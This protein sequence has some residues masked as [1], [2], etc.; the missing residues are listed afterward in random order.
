MSS[1]WLRK[2]LKNLYGDAF[3][4]LDTVLRDCPDHTWT[5]SV[6]RVKAN[7]GHVLPIT[8]G[9]G[10]HL[11][12]EERLQMHSAFCNVAFHVLFFA[13][14]YLSGGLGETQPPPPFEAE[15]AESPHAAAAHLLA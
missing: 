4:A 12:E 8:A 14:H 5:T 3:D 1:D 6:W 7:D 9:M 13:D 10:A 11:R 15:Q 2:S